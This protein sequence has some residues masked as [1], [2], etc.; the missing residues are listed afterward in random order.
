MSDRHLTI[1]SVLIGA[2]L[3]VWIGSFFV[4]AILRSFSEELGDRRGLN[5]GG[6]II[7]YTERLLIY[8]FVLVDAPAAIGFLITAKSIYSFDESSSNEQHKRSQYV[9]IGT[10]VSF[11]YAVTLSYLVRW[12]LRVML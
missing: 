12:T 6:Q 3:V 2:G 1:G 9:I 8:I 4:S 5:G 7:G 11:A 10:L